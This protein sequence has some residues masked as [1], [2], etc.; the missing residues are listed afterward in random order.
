MK[1]II[2]TNVT[3]EPYFGMM[4]NE[5]FSSKSLSFD[6]VTLSFMESFKMKKSFKEADIVVSLLNFEVLLPNWYI[7]A[8]WC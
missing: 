3:L 7:E 2:V 5:L 8:S 6:V 4:L 1:I